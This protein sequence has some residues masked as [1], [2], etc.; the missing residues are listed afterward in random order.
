[1]TAFRPS[2][3]APKSIKVETQR[4]LRGA[5][6]KVEHAHEYRAEVRLYTT[7]SA[8]S[9]EALF[10]YPEHACVRVCPPDFPV[11]DTRWPWSMTKGPSP[12]RPHLPE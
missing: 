5:R 6:I 10:S 4:A 9:P 3:Q 12:L 1:M 7:A 2:E 11:S 8:E